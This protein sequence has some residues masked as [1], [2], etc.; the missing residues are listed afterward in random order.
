MNH[1]SCCHF[2]RCQRMA[3]ETPNIIT[4]YVMRSMYFDSTFSIVNQS[5]PLCVLKT[6]IAVKVSH[7]PESH[8]GSA[9]PNRS[10][11][12]IAYQLG[13]PGTSLLRD[14][15]KIGINIYFQIDRYF[16][17]ALIYD[18]RSKVVQE[19]PNCWHERVQRCRSSQ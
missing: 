11:I 17:S 19:L 4:G 18:L 6:C 5:L 1:D 3:F 12:P 10:L 9:R 14:I 7:L 16:N 8:L 2:V 15:H 13:T